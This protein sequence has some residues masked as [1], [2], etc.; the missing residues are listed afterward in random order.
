MKTTKNKIEDE[1]HCNVLLL[2]RLSI[3]FS[4]ILDK[5]SDDRKMRGKKL[6]EVF[7]FKIFESSIQT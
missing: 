5:K 6:T 2:L 7:W 1:E 4:V 3:F